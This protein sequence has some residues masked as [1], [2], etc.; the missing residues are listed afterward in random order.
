MDFQVR[1]TEPDIFLLASIYPVKYKTI[2]DRF[3]VFVCGTTDFHG[4][5]QN[6]IV[7]HLAKRKNLIDSWLATHTKDRVKIDQTSMVFDSYDEALLFYLR[8]KK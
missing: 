2:P 1:M 7:A 3:A 8:F 5:E 6:D 4:W